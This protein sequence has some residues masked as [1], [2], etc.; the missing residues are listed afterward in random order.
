LIVAGCAGYVAWSLLLPAAARRR[1]ALVLL[2]WRWPGI[3]TRRLQSQAKVAPDCHCD[4]CERGATGPPAAQPV[5]WQARR[6]R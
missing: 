5:H 6:P 2:R 1:I 4:G 3:V